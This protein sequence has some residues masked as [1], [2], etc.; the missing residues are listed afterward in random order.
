MVRPL[1]LARVILAAALLTPAA[2]HGLQASPDTAA[3]AARKAFDFLIG[4]W[5]VESMT[6]SGGT[7]TPGKGEVYRFEKQLS[8]VLLVGYWHFNRGTAA[9]P[10]FVDAVYYSGFDNT[11]QMWSFYYVSP[12]SAQYWPGQ[13]D[14]RRW[15]FFNEFT[16]DGRVTLQR[17]SWERMDER[18]VHRV[19]E[20]STDRGGTWKR[21][22]WVLRRSSPA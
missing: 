11:R 6:D 2:A 16:I 15:Y 21:W 7:T 13:R 4:T 18:T 8:G 20:N 5:N 14:G 3:A 10:D 9:K 1:G 17:Q 19:I 22:I 12:Q